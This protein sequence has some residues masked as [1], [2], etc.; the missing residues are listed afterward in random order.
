MIKRFN[1][2]IVESVVLKTKKGSSI[3]RYK[4]VG[5]KMG[6]DLY[7]HKNY[8]DEYID[9][10][11]YNELKSH[12]PEGVKFNIIKYNEK[13]ETISFINSPDFDTADEPIVSDAYKVT[14]EG[15]V[16]KTKEKSTPQIYHHKWM[17]VKDDYKGFSVPKSVDRSK[18]WLEVSDK[19]N[20]SKIGSKGYWVDEVLPLL[21]NSLWS[22]RNQEYTSAKTSINQI[23]KPVKYLLEENRLKD[24][25]VNLDIGGGKY[26]NMT[27]YLAEWGIMNYVY[28][29]YNRSDEHNEMVI[30]KTKDGQADSVTMFN[31]LNVIKDKEDQIIALERAKNAL[32]DGGKA[33]I[34][35]NYYVK[36]KEPGAVP[37][38]DSYQQNYKLA[39]ILPIVQEVFPNAYLDR[40][41]LC[42]V[43]SK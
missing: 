31:V 22:K 7:F 43:A 18:R 40:K 37:G 28:D 5:K 13:N 41:V 9:K 23:P 34:Y 1:E 38:R 24:R 16:S 21:E 27:Q 4:S 33:Y 11:F 19:I 25:S 32:K 42:V 3:R 12:L 29:P 30:E 36:G 39:D 15:K 14:K 17:F 20:M 26:E 10:D 8:V 2:H 35:S 6:N